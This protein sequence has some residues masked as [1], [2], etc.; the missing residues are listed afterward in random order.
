MAAD[1]TLSQK[2]S[3]D[4]DRWDRGLQDLLRRAVGA[5]KGATVYFSETGVSVVW[6]RRKAFR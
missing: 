3:V 1:P 2:V 4:I 5:P 6:R